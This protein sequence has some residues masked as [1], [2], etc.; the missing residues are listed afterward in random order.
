MMR[1]MKRYELT[2]KYITNE[3]KD[4]GEYRVAHIHKIYTYDR[5]LISN[6]KGQI[7]G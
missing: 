5:Y 2:L 7:D 3:L 4:F 6:K 1:C